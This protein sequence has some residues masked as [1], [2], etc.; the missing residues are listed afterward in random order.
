M[1]FR[2]VVSYS[3]IH[4]DRRQGKGSDGRQSG[5]SAEKSLHVRPEYTKMNVGRFSKIFVLKVNGAIHV[6]RKTPADNFK[7]HKNE[8]IREERYGDIEI[9]ARGK[10]RRQEPCRQYDIG[11]TEQ[12]GALKYKS[13]AERRKTN[14]NKM[15]IGLQRMRM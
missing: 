10:A 9:A 14:E 12:T 11:K 1:E 13:E 4:R 2:I 8:A 6:N 3:I 5:K 15:R 7:I